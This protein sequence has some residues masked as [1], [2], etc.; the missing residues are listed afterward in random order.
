MKKYTSTYKQK[1][2]DRP[3]KDLCTTTG[4]FDLQVQQK[5]LK[6][7]VQDN[8]DWRTLLLY[9]QIGSGKTC[10]AITMAEAYKQMRPITDVKVVLPARLK[11]NFID[12]LISPCGAD[13]YISK[14]EF[15]SYISGEPKVKRKIKTKFTKAIG[16]KYNILSFEKWKKGANEAGDLKEWVKDFTKNSLIIV[17]EV[18]N[19]IPQTYRRQKWQEM[20]VTHRIPRA[21]QSSTSLLFKYMM[22][23][24]HPTAKFIIMT[25]T[26]IF[27]SVSQFKELAEIMN[28]GHTVEVGS[29]LS[30]VIK[31]FK[32]KVSYFPGTSVNAYPKVKYV[33]H[34]IL[35]SATQDAKTAKV[36]QNVE[37]DQNFEKEAFLSKQRQLAISVF[38]KPSKN[39]E[40]PHEYCPKLE[41]FMKEINRTRKGKHLVYTTFV[42][43]GINVLKI[44]LE[45][46]GWI[47]AKQGVPS[48]PFKTYAIWDGTTKDTE[49]SWLKTL[50]NSKDNR[51]G[52]HVR[53]IIGSPSIK[54][55]VSF[56]HIQHLH[57]IDPVWN[58]SAKQQVEG[59]AIRFCSHIEMPETKR[60]VNVH[61]YKIMPRPN[62]EVVKTCDQLIYDIIIPDKVKTIEICEEALKEVALDNVLF[63]EMYKKK[64]VNKEDIYINAPKNAIEK[65][66][67]CPKKRRPLL[68]IC[69]PGHENKLN[70]HGDECCYKIRVKKEKAPKAPKAE[71]K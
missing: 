2:D 67:T 35:L 57:V 31:N 30:S 34:E 65:T 56:K 69:L 43:K 25:A 12:E 49:K 8:T 47:R 59:R 1:Y 48:V 27:N 11:T 24:A 66:S 68:G 52:E 45:D 36:Q 16:E 18:H 21:T 26:P 55:G 40:D 60:T 15:E 3:M 10:T 32:G 13:K 22:L 61:L 38:D 23:H 41:R 5:F 29:R 33:Y 7:F 71:K 4:S 70:L 14:E 17:D 39:A 54:E 9:H 44:L 58:A 53:L 63:G 42:K 46:A 20:L 62:G 37:D 64:L 19:L 51:Y 6:Q 50:V 28:P